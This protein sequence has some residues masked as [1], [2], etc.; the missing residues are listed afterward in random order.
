MQGYLGS[1][2]RIGSGLYRVQNPVSLEHLEPDEGV[3][4]GKPTRS[5]G[6]EDQGKE[7]VHRSLLLSLDEEGQIDGPTHGS[8][9]QIRGHLVRQVRGGRCRCEDPGAFHPVPGGHPSIHTERSHH[10]QRSQCSGDPAPPSLPAQTQDSRRVRR[11]VLRGFPGLPHAHRRP[12]F[13]H[14]PGQIFVLVRVG[15]ESGTGGACRHGCSGT[16]SWS[17]GGRGGYPGPDSGFG[18]RSTGI[19]Q[20]SLPLR[21]EELLQERSRGLPPG[22]RV[23]R[24]SLFQGVRQHRMVT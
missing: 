23:L 1:S 8:R 2:G 6:L 7:G 9:A 3:R 22:I 16:A 11:A 21:P 17:R 18:A 20:P 14:G 19:H 4:H 15:A 13:H 24:Q 10:D 5:R 12:R